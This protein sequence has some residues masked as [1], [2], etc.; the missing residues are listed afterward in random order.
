MTS[1][2]SMILAVVE[3]DVVADAESRSVVE[4]DNLGTISSAHLVAER[5]NRAWI[6]ASK[7]AVSICAVDGCLERRKRLVE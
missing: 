4:V 6:G 5:Q 1:D 2:G 7:L 3:S